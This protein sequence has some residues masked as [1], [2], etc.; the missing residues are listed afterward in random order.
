MSGP[1]YKKIKLENYV[2]APMTHYH[3]FINKTKLKKS[4]G[5]KKF[6]P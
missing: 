3:S 6:F 1:F 4:L 5:D 2:D